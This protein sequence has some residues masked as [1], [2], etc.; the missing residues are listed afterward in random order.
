M[1]KK[2]WLNRKICFIITLV[3]LVC[4][5]MATSSRAARKIEFTSTNAKVLIQKLNQNNIANDT[6]IGQILGLSGDE[7]LQLLRKNTDFNR[8]T[9]YRYQQ[10]YRGIPVWGMQ[11]IISRGPSHQVVRLLSALRRVQDLH[12]QKDTTAVW[13]FRNEKYETNIY[14]DKND[15][16]HPCYVVSFF[17]DTQCGNP[18]RF[19]HFIDVN[20]GKVL[21]SFDMLNYADGVGPGGNLKVGYY[22]YGTDYPPFCVTEDGGTCT[23]NCTEV[24]TVDLN[25]GTT[26]TT[27]YSY[28]C[29]ENT[30]KEINGGYCPLNDA[31]YFGQAVYDMYNTWYGV[32]PL[33]FPL[34]L[35]CHYSTNYENAFW[36]GSTMT[37]GDG[38]TT[39]YPL[40]ALDIIAH[41]VSHGFTEFN[42]GLIYSGES[43][44]I[45]VAFSDIAGEAAKY[46]MKGSNNFMVAYDIFK[47]PGQALRYLYDPPLD[48]RSIDHFSDYYEGLDVHYSSGIFNKAF[49]LIAT[50]PG[51]NTKMAFDI[52]VKANQDYWWPSITFHQ[53]ADGVMNAAMDYGYSYQDVANAFAQVGICYCEWINADFTASA[54]TIYEGESVT[55]TNQSSGFP[56]PY[57][58]DWVFEGG[59]PGAS[60]QQNP[61]ITYNTKGKYTVTL[62]AYGFGSDTETK[63]DY[64]K[65]IKKPTEIY[66]KD[67]TQTVKKHGNK[68]NSTA[69]ITILDIDSAPV[70]KAAVYITWTGV[71]SGSDS[72]I[73]GPDGTVTFQSGKINSTGPFTIT[74][75][76]VTHPVGTYN[77]ALNI[78][79][80]DKTSF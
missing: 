49:Y 59:T 47:N 19:I 37:F 5:F 2:K 72:G 54:T 77:P 32:P 22:Y 63:A 76:S 30:H 14:I 25:H 58:W 44:G 60:T 18:S 12:K 75:D 35:R 34:T 21:D 66:V 67:I 29:Y 38:Y 20:T 24:R 4:C 56:N 1:T 10:T 7:A 45:N 26:G 64:I 13:N 53:A 15:K 46:Y 68:Y 70:N 8:V 17:A 11:T 40:V 52:F 33:P 36:D 74:V 48:G 28:T 23:M 79:T 9:H 69:V 3:F 6:A 42:S 51:W 62:T 57:A 78:E 39:F 43:G 65:V 71:V 31:Q 50:S 80:S 27:P 16:A 73:T 41:E 61:T 55:F